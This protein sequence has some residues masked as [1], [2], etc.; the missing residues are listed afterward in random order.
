[1]EAGPAVAS[2][3]LGAEALVEARG[4]VV[5]YREQVVLAG[6]DLRVQGGETVAVVGASGSG[7]SSLLH[8]MAGLVRPTSGTVAVDGAPLPEPGT[9]RGAELRRRRFGFVFQNG[10]L[11]NDL[12]IAENVALP[13]LLDG[14]RRREALARAALLLTDLGIAQLAG[15][16]PGAVS[17]GEAQRAAIARALVANPAVLFADEP[18]GAL[19]SNNAAVVM[20][21]LFQACRDRGA[22][23]LLV[24]HDLAL[25][26]RADR[27]LRMQDGRLTV[28]GGGS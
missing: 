11:V 23:L 2:A 15:R 16:L 8:C 3:A 7:K 21:L 19:D 27:V 20:Q 12:T 9:E 4:I 26:A 17:G 10:L 6:V 18:T 24:T 1:M 22:A 5:R 13:L 28:G 14:T 25:A